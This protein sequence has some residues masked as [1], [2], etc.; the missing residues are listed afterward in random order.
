MTYALLTLVNNDWASGKVS[1]MRGCLYPKSSLSPAC[2]NL[3]Q[4]ATRI[5]FWFSDVFLN[6]KLTTLHM[7]LKKRVTESLMLLGES[8]TGGGSPIFRHP[9][10]WLCGF[11]LVFILSF[12]VLLFTKRGHSQGLGVQNNQWQ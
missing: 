1:P 2:S 6:R 12:C 11:R 3:Q 5:V 7:E 8:P 4:P 10:D 9:Q